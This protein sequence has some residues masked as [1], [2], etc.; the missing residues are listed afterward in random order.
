MSLQ[1]SSRCARCVNCPHRVECADGAYA[2]LDQWKGSAIIDA[3]RQRIA[4]TAKQLTARSEPEQ[5][6]IDGAKPKPEQTKTKPRK[7]GNRAVKRAGGR[8]EKSGLFA[9]YA[10]ELAAG[11]NPGKKPWE[12]VFFELLLAGNMTRSKLVRTYIDDF[13]T[14]YKYGSA[15]T[16]ACTAITMFEEALF[17]RCSPDGDI[18]LHPEITRDTE[19]YTKPQTL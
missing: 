2:F 8:S 4:L 14:C 18:T 6:V 10:R 1:V 15:R 17:I 12:I 19:T 11:R 3:E 13:R 16:R 9:L 7:R 5:S